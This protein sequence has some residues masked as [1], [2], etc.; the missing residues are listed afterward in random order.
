LLSI[1]L[2]I[3][4]ALGLWLG[5]RGTEDVAVCS[6]PGSGVK[7]VIPESQQRKDTKMTE[8]GDVAVEELVVIVGDKRR[9]RKLRHAGVLAL[10]GRGIEARDSLAVLSAIV[11]DQ[12]EPLDLRVASINA[13]GNIGSG[14]EEPVAA[15]DA[16]VR[17]EIE[18]LRGSAIF[19]LGRLGRPAILIASDLLSGKGERHRIA[20][21]MI[22][23]EIGENVRDYEKAVQLLIRAV[24][25]KR[26][27]VRAAAIT[28]LG[29]IRPEEAVAPL[30]ERLREDTSKP[31]RCEAARSLGRM[32][33][34]AEPALG[35]LKEL[36]ASMDDENEVLLIV[37]RM[38]IKKIEAA[39]GP[40]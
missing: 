4:L 1:G 11:R 19:A 10:G 13:L 37:S 21:A 15:L 33:A 40:Q 28:A 14:S 20:G 36:V 5:H 32:G 17:S 9:D 26:E 39:R 34:L 25:D 27:A 7:G 23:S 8:T 12:T 16:A 30:V 31:V 6:L 3:G 24:T 22:L 29:Q 35:A 2:V 18:D 38:A